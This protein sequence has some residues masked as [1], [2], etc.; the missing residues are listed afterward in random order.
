MRNIVKEE[1]R[2]AFIIGRRGNIINL[3]PV[4]KLHAE[5]LKD[6]AT[7]CGI[8]LSAAILNS[9]S[10]VDV[11][12]ILANQGYVPAVE[13][14]CQGRDTLIYYYNTGVMTELQKEAFSKLELR[15]YKVVRSFAYEEGRFKEIKLKQKRRRNNV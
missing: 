14:S 15:G 9:F 6:Y 1:D 8:S 10:F 12:E 4:T 13:T 7:D 2:I 3:G 5:L 11:A